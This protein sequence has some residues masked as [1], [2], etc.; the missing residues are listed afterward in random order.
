[1]SVGWLVKDGQ[2]SRSSS[3]TWH[4][5]SRQSRPHRRP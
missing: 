3:R 4:G 2:R 1:M 5:R